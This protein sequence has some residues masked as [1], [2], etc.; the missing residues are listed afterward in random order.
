MPRTMISPAGTASP[1]RSSSRRREKERHS[2]ERHNPSS[3]SFDCSSCYTLVTRIRGKHCYI[4]LLLG[5][6]FR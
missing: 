6:A 4:A 1:R 5:S 3:S 2:Y